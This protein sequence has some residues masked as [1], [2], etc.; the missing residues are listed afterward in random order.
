LG[1]EDFD[2]RLVARLADEFS[3]RHSV[4]LRKDKMALQR[5]KDAAEKAK[6]EP[7]S[8]LETVI[9]LPFLAVGAGNQPLHLERVVKR[10]EFEMLNGDLID[11]T[12]D[13][14]AQAVRDAGL[15]VEDIDNVVLVGGMTRMP[16]V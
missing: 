3:Q 10:N 14:C 11:R 13:A 6:H 16:S 2:N 9:N 15:G 12:I 1:G 4:D 7:S 8:S 5:L